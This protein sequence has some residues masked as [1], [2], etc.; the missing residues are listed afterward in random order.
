MNFGAQSRKKKGKKLHVWVGLDYMVVWEW[1]WIKGF[2]G[3]DWIKGFVLETGFWV[4]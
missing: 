3:L 4:G 1:D 2:M